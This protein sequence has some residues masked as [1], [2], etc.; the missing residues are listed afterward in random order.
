MTKKAKMIG[1]A[2]A[3]GVL[4]AFAGATALLADNID[5][6]ASAAEQGIT[7]ADTDSANWYFR[8]GFAP[9]PVAVARPVAVRRWVPGYWHGV[10]YHRGYWR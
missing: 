2:V 6:V 3:L 4:G 5:E 1:A 8:F 10:R 7:S 9:R